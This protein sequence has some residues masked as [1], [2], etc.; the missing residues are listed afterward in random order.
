M[1][2]VSFLVIVG[3]NQLVNP[4]LQQKL[5][6][7][8]ST[9]GFLTTL[10]GLGVVAGGALGGLLIDRLGRPHAA[11]IG[12]A[13]ASLG[14]LGLAN[15]LSLGL[16]WAIVALFGLAY[17]T[18]QTIIFALCMHYTDTRI[19]ASMFSILMAFTNIGQAVGL[20]LGGALADRIGYGWTFAALAGVNLLV[21]PLLPLVFRRREKPV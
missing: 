9:A 16:A 6:I 1:G 15:A 7:D 11:L 17:G 3:A 10:W 14:V 4:S 13:A 21:L 8:L 18:Y 19:A 12:A 5:G 2:L 20:G